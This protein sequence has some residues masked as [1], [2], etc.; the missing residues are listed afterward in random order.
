VKV[1]FVIPQDS[2]AGGIRAVSI[3]A[4][5]LQKRGHNVTVVAGVHPPQTYKEKMKRLLQPRQRQ[6]AAAATTR[7]SYF[8]ALDIHLHTLERH[9][10][11]RGSDLPDADVIIAT[12][13]ET[14]EWIAPLSASKG[15]KVYFIQHHETFDYLPKSRVEATYRLPFYQITVAQWLV[16]ILRDRHQSKQVS[17]VPY[18]VDLTQFN[19]PPRVKAAVPTVGLMYATAPWKGVDIALEAFQHALK[20]LPN[21]RLAA[22]GSEQPSAQLPL[23]KNTQYYFQ[24]EQDSLKDIYA[25]CDAWL[26]SSRVEGFGLPILEA[27][28]CRTPVIAVPTG[29]APELL[30]NGCGMLLDRNDPVLIAQ[31]I[32]DT[33]ALDVTAWQ[34]LSEYAYQTACQR[35]WED[36]AHDFEAALL[37][38]IA[39][40]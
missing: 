16:E 4:D 23:P 15:A 26:F 32:H 24:P 39:K 10:P 2:L 29:A 37:Q 27:M 22:F 12:W 5:R 21:L 34:K 7:R 20:D 36:A 40:Q 28:A 3:Y 19:S 31:A 30:S 25:Q 13:W 38:A 35:S 18:G 17:L 6:I 1:T 9:R 33:A 11:V 14:A 8:D